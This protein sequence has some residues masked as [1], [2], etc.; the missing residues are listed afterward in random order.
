MNTMNKFALLIEQLQQLH[1]IKS[2]MVV[3]ADQL[4]LS[5]RDKLDILAITKRM[6]KKIKKQMIEIANQ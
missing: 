5:E 2:A 4:S 3:M 1:D 6:E